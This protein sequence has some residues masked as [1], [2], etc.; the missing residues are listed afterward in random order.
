[1]LDTKWNTERHGFSELKG[2]RHISE[3]SSK[4]EGKQENGNLL[5]KLPTLLLERAQR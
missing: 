1:M 4:T 5:L 2:H 3:F